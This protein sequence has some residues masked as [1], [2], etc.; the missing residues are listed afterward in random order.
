MKMTEQLFQAFF[1]ISI[2]AVILTNCHTINK[3]KDKKDE[4]FTSVSRSNLLKKIIT[5]ESLTESEDQDL[6]KYFTYF[7][8]FGYCTIA[9]IK[10]GKCCSFILPNRVGERN[11]DGWVLIDYGQTS[12][13]KLKWGDADNT[14][15][16]FRNDHFKKTVVTFPGTNEFSQLVKEFLHHGLKTFY[17]ERHENVMI[18]EYFGS[19]AKELIPIIMREENLEQMKLDSGYQIIFAGHSLGGAMGAAFCYMILDLGLI[20]TAKNHPVLYTYGQ[21]RTGNYQFK[22]ALEKETSYI[23]RMINE[24]DVVPLIP[25][26]ALKELIGFTCKETEVETYWHTEPAI[27][28]VNTTNSTQNSVRNK[29]KIIDEILFKFRSKLTLGDLIKYYSGAFMVDLNALN[30]DIKAQNDF[31]DV[32]IEYF[33]NRYYAHIYYYGVDIGSQ[34]YGR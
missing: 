1:L 20:S 25:P 9:Q 3:I 17:N 2:A 29:G 34:C 5:R 6:G 19:R 14:Y 7:A 23:M 33:Q 28:I 16:V 21:P 10:E 11:F 4:F 8:S 30:S 27:V 24:L 26:C 15:A 18:N 22:D 13:K 32:I 12:S 31:I